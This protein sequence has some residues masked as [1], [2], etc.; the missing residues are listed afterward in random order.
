MQQANMNAP[1]ALQQSS[2]EI[3]A[4]KGKHMILGYF[5]RNRKNQEIVRSIYGQLTG[6]ARDPSYYMHMNVPDTVMGRYE[7]ISIMMILFLRRTGQAS[8][9]VQELAQ[10]VVDSFFAEIDHSIRELGVGDNSV[11]KRMKK[12]ARMF[13]GRAEAYRAVL[14]A[15]DAAALAE[16]LRRNIH[17]GLA[18]EAVAESGADMSALAEAVLRL[19]EEFSGRGEA[20]ILSGNILQR[21]AESV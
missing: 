16:A 13:Y 9:P 6:A 3:M 19:D 15:G 5:S 21:P 2:A 20:G 11:P 4:R 14:D 10:D 12:L 17:P 8:T 18:G 7:M 1:H